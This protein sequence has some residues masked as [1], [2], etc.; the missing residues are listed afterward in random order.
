MKK[1][2]VIG[3]IILIC[4]MVVGCGKG[5]SKRGIKAPEI[6]NYSKSDSI[7][8]DVYIDG[9]ASMGGYVNYPNNTIFVEGVKGIE[10]TVTNNW[11]KETIQYVKFGD[12]FS[13]LDRES[14]L[15]FNKLEFYN[16]VDTRLEEVINILDDNKV[17]I[18]VTDFFQT[19]QD[20]DSLLISLKN[21]CFVKEKAFAVM[22]MK[23]QFNGK[24]YDIGKNLQS[25]QY[26]TTEDKASY[27]PFYFLII[28]NEDNVRKFLL[29]YKNNK[30]A[31]SE[32]KQ[33]LFASNIGISNVLKTDKIHT[34]NGKDNPMAEINT[35]LPNDNVT[36]QYR[37]KGKESKANLFIE[38]KEIV[39]QLP[40]EFEFESVNLE[41]WIAGDNNSGK[42][43]KIEAE[44]FVKGEIKSVAVDGDNGRLELQLRV[45]PRAINSKEGQYRV[46]FKVV[47]EQKEYIAANSLFEEWN[48]DE[49]TL[50]NGGELAQYGNKTLHISSFI[51]LVSRLS[52][53]MLEP[54]L[55]GLYVYFDVI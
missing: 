20:V 51:S 53:E 1:I 52:F 42:F 10:R 32:I 47:P 15:N 6:A 49:S 44:E 31:D 37:V 36:K 9:T 4:F 28:G 25:M 21:K 40:E 17:S 46:C 48:F 55:K 38:S 27:R 23:S 5:N 35:L 7:D 16:Q 30:L 43:E 2:W 50:E 22:G 29:A 18:I 33:V 39:G 45:K 14:F 26:C 41:R 54:G 8:V 34:L 13:Q 12:S 24:I 3:C 11:K 19:N